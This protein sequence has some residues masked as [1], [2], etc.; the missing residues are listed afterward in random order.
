MKIAGA[1]IENT[2]LIS[3]KVIFMHSG[4]PEAHDICA[5]LRMTAKG[6]E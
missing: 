4:E 5:A 1:A 6:S 3:N 2:G